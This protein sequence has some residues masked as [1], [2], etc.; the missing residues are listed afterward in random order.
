MKFE[1]WV[2][3]KQVKGLVGVRT[4]ASKIEETAGAKA[5]WWEEARCIH[6]LET[7]LEWLKGTQVGKEVGEVGTND[8]KPVPSQIYL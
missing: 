2:R 3:A 6:I 5:L 4:E 1:R 8:T 7:M